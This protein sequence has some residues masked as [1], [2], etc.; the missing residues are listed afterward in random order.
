MS[1]TVSFSTVG[2]MRGLL[3]PVRAPRLKSLELA[4]DVARWAARDARD[5]PQSLEIGAMTDSALNGLAP[6]ST[7]RERLALLDRAGRDIGDE[8][9][10][11]V[12]THEAFQIFRHLDDTLTD[13]L[14]TA[15]ARGRQ[16]PA[17]DVGS[18]DGVGFDHLDDRSR[19]Q[20]RKIRRGGLDLRIGGRFRERNHQIDVAPWHRRLSGS[21]LELAHL[22]RNVRGR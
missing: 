11:R 13:R 14:P 15:R 17:G 10:P 6:T 19:L 7:G 22:L 16:M 21:A 1:S 5:R 8:A 4:H 20:G 9:R 2:F 18:R 12:A 3:I